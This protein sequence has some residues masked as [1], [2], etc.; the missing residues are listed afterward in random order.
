MGTLIFDASKNRDIENIG[1]DGNAVIVYCLV[2][3]N[4]ILTDYYQCISIIS[5][6][7]AALRPA[8]RRLSEAALRSYRKYCQPTRISGSGARQSPVNTWSVT[9]DL[10]RRRGG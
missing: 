9:W 10:G 8:T 3:V 6:R 7:A 4:P 1:M 2:H 5:I